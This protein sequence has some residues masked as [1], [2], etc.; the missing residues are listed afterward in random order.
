MVSSYVEA[1]LVTTSLFVRVRSSQSDGVFFYTG[2][3]NGDSILLQLTNG[4]IA[5]SVDL[6]SGSVTIATKANT[7]NDNQWHRVK[8]ERVKRLVNLTVDDSDS[9]TG[10]TLGIFDRFSL[11][12][13]KTSFILS[14]FSRDDLNK[15]VQTFSGRNFTGCLQELVFNGYDLFRK[16]NKSA[17]EITS[18]GKFSK[19]CPKPPTTPPKVATTLYKTPT[20]VPVPSNRSTPG[21][22]K[23]TKTSGAFSITLPPTTS[24]KSPCIVAGISC[25]STTAGVP[26]SQAQ[27]VT[28]SQVKHVTTPSSNQ[29]WTASETSS[30]STIS[31]KERTEDSS[32]TNPSSLKTHLSTTKSAKIYKNVHTTISQDFST[33]K[34]VTEAYGGP[35]TTDEVMMASQSKVSE[36]D[37]TIYF[38]I[39]AVVGLLAFLLAILIIVKVNWA[40]RKKYAVRGRKYEKD[41]WADNGSFQR[42]TKESKP[43]V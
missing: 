19:T 16:Y 7:Y 1:S 43:L 27:T 39:A 10:T 25:E 20:T 2:H 18:Q 28:S 37:L 6:G 26:T 22:F 41:Y 42:A 4:R 36:G 17:K 9:S 8:L 21:T 31:P 35:R 13:S 38:V 14:G 3:V 24:K 23:T 5:A 34:K 29:S 30:Q 33:S 11:P 15:N 40:S 32:H 12:K